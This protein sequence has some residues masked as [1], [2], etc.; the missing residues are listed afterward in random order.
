MKMIKIVAIAATLLAG[1][2]ASH[3][4][5]YNAMNGVQALDAIDDAVA[6]TVLSVD[7]NEAQSLAFDNNVASVQQRI[8]NNPY[9]S[10]TIADQGYNLDQ[11]VGVDGTENDLTIYAL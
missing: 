5:P 2:S 7:A 11:I 9:L 3:A 6:A 1:V 4:S 8:K 10:R